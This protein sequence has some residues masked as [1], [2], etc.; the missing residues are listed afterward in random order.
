MYDGGEQSSKPSVFFQ[1]PVS[2]WSDYSVGN[3]E[4][5]SRVVAGLL[6]PAVAGSRL[7]LLFQAADNAHFQATSLQSEQISVPSRAAMVFDMCTQGRPV[8]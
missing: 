4:G 5:T 1:V 3:L 7:S 6:L 8:V 2:R